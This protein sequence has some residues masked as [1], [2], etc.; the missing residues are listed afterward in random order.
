MGCGASKEASVIQTT[1]PK[2]DDSKEKAVMFIVEKGVL[3]GIKVKS[4]QTAVCFEIP[5]ED[6][7]TNS[8]NTLKNSISNS[9]NSL[10][11]MGLSNEDIH[12][13]LANAEERWKVVVYF[14]I[15]GIGK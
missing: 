5:L 9:K 2:N 6:L 13:K 3:P 8:V 10:P 11:K 1:I 15:L 12:S 4:S 7:A 14:Y